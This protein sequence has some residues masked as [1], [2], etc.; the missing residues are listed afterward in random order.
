MEKDNKNELASQKDSQMSTVLAVFIK[1]PKSWYLC[2]KSEK[3]SKAFFLLTRH[4]SDEH[5]LKVRMREKALDLVAKSQRLLST[6]RTSEVAQEI[7]LE[8]LSLISL[9]DI[10]LVSELQSERNH[11]VVVRE[12]EN[13]IEELST[14]A[15]EK[16]ASAYIPTSLFDMSDIVTINQE[17][18]ASQHFNISSVSNVN[19]THLVP[20]TRPATKKVSSGN[21]GDQRKGG[22]QEAIIQAIKAKGEVSIKD[23]VTVVKGCSEKTIQ[24]ELTALVGAGAVSKTGE[25]RWSRYAI[26]Q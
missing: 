12:L 9:S 13:F 1:D 10:A 7:V 17:K 8:A 21:N 16:T 23:L 4:L 6:S 3:I 26:I 20:T 18:E 11:T 14:W 25:R 15:R 19:K 5:M 24:R 2:K 22:R